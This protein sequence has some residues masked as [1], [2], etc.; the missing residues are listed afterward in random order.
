MILHIIIPAAEKV[1]NITFRWL[2]QNLTFNFLHFVKGIEFGIVI[3]VAIFFLLASAYMVLRQYKRLP[4]SYHIVVYDVF[5]R[6]TVIDGLRQTFATYDAAES[7]ANLYSEMYGRQQY[8]F[9]VIGN[10]L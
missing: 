1:L 2:D 4:K 7:Y 6:E 8:K 3:T 5:G 9:E 10:F